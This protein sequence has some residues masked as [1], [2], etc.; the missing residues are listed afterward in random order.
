MARNESTVLVTGASGGI[1]LELA[2]CFARGGHRLVVT[3][4][5][6]P[7][8]GAV[9]EE[10]VRLGAPAAEPLA[11]DLGRT[12]G[13]AGLVAE[14]GRRDLW[15]AVV[16]NNAG[17]GRLGAFA[18]GDIDEQLDMIRVNVASLVDLTHRL[19]PG[20]LAA[21]GRGG[22]LNVASTAAFQPGPYMAIYYATKAFVLSFSEALA[23]EL[24]GR[25]RVTCLCPGPV[26][27]GFQQRAGFEDGV[28]LQ[29][30]ALP[31]M[32]AEAVAR[33]GYRGFRRGK[34]VVIPGLANRTGAWG[35]RLS[36]RLATRIVERMQRRR[37]G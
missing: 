23:V 3:A 31:W 13:A 30:K 4:R 27:T 35:T 18:A 29:S 10:L 33:A 32:S 36:R 7:R 24:A 17:Y 25:A 6:A 11:G 21:E 19:L 26:R 20:I 14:L 8:L 28:T 1:G 34:R 15:P 37:D 22:V 9:A 2:R 5:D 16:V 12:D